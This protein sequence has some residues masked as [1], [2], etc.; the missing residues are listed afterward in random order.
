[1]RQK[2]PFDWQVSRSWKFKWLIFLETHFNLWITLSNW[3]TQRWAVVPW[4]IRRAA[5]FLHKSVG[6]VIGRR[7]RQRNRS[8]RSQK[9]AE[10]IGK[11]FSRLFSLLTPFLHVSRNRIFIPTHSKI[12]NRNIC[13]STYLIEF[14]FE[15]VVVEITGD[16]LQL[17][18]LVE[19]DNGVV[20]G[21]I[22]DLAVV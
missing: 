12:Q 16:V 22:D 10:I 5:G 8:C 20:R 3:W 4:R 11:E 2:W 21:S 14:A 9:R 17:E 6:K 15:S 19:I 18:M 1:M 13:P 7:G